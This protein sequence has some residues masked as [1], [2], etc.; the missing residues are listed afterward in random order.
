VILE[1]GYDEKIDMWSLGCILYELYKGIPIFQGVNELDQL[2]KIVEVVGQVPEA[3]INVSRRRQNFF[4]EYME[5]KDR[6]GNVVKPGSKSVAGL[7]K[8]AEKNFIDFLIECFR[9][10]PKERIDTESALAHPWIKGN[11]M[12]NSMS[13]RSGLIN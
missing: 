8:N 13:L 2:C 5:L 3:L 6:N 7:I 10:D 4:D 9:I 11:K 12:Q 1:T